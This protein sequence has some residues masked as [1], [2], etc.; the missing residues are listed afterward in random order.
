MGRFRSQ[1]GAVGAVT[2]SVADNGPGIAEAIRE[3]LFHPFVSYGKENGTGLG[4]TVVQKIVQDHGGEVLMERTADAHTVF[5]III[6]GR[7]PQGSAEDG[8]DMLTPRPVGS[9]NNDREREKSIRHSD[10]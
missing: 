8:D 10:T 2:I 4:L 3:K 6:P 5:R 9:L 7:S 1:S